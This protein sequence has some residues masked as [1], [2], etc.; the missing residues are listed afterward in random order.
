[1]ENRSSNLE[2]RNIEMLQM[3]EEREQ[4][5]KRKEEI[6]WEI[7]D[8]IRNCNI[9]IDI[10]E[11]EGRE[12]RE[13]L[14][15]EIMAENFPNLEKELEFYVNEANRTPNYTNAKRPSPRRISV[16]PAKV[17]DK[18][19][20]MGSK[21]EENNLLNNPYQALSGLFSRNLTGYERVE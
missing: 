18:E 13:G 5:L 12:K 8:S 11:G 4:R 17:D 15:K 19:N 3:E 1:M 6:L 16:K 7:S 9:I 21:V 2:D 14:F 10:P 20:I